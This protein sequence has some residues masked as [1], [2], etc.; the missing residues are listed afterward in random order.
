MLFSSHTAASNS[1]Y[2]HSTYTSRQTTSMV[3]QKQKGDN[4]TLL[5][6]INTL[7]PSLSTCYRNIIVP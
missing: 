3:V 4:S 6:E 5:K 1:K 2:K 7:N